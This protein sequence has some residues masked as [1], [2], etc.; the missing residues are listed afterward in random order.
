[1]LDATVSSDSYSSLG[2]AL[3]KIM[4]PIALAPPVPVLTHRRRR[5]AR[6]ENRMERGA[7]ERKNACNMT[8]S[9]SLTRGFE[10]QSNFNFP[11]HFTSRTL[12]RN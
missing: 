9:T 2:I 12:H 4:G 5:R 10:G 1:M 7:E 11:M 6:M 8:H 3:D